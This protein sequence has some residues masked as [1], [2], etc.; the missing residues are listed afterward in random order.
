MQFFPS[1]KRVVA[2]WKHSRIFQESHK[3]TGSFLPGPETRI[4]LWQWE[5]TG[6]LKSFYYIAN[7]FV[8]IGRASFMWSAKPEKEK[9]KDSQKEL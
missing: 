1:K 2:S 7:E 8:V 6:L 9:S 3:C 4:L 5:I